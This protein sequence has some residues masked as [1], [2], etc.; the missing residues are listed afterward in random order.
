MR[1]IVARIGM[2][3]N[4]T[5]MAALMFALFLS[6]TARAAEVSGPCLFFLYAFKGQVVRR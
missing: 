3:A 1:R 2:V 6:A 4:R 5:P